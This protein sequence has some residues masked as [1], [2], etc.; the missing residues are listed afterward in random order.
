MVN[1]VL[2]SIGILI[3]SIFIVFHGFKTFKTITPTRMKTPKS[4][5]TIGLVKLT[6]VVSCVVPVIV[7]IKSTNQ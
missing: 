3:Y 1:S 6:L 2:I 7:F 5:T 4:K